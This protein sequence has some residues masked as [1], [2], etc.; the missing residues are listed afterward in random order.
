MR[1]HV[2]TR[3]IE[4]LT[5]DLRRNP[6]GGNATSEPACE[7]TRSHLNPSATRV[8]VECR[9][10]SIPFVRLYD[11][12][13]SEGLREVTTLEDHGALED[14]TENMVWPE[15]EFL[16]VRLHPDG[17]A[18]VS[19]F[20]PPIHPLNRDDDRRFPLVIRM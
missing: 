19:L 10:P 20:F 16:S 13:G 2:A 12:V 1:V 8:V 7:S 4:C 9:G 14:L 17:F 11:T 3:K 18:R 6:L 5:C 15:R